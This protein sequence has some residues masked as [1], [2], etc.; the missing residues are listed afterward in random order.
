MIVESLIFRKKVLILSHNKKKIYS[1][2]NFI[3]KVENYKN[4]ENIESV[5]LCD[6]IENIEK[7]IFR[8]LKKKVNNNKIDKQRNFVFFKNRYKYEKNISNIAENIID[9]L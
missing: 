9:N 6:N 7:D 8:L 5:Q 4:I 2:Y 3:K 1:H